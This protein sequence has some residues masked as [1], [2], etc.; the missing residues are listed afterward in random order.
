MPRLC[1]ILHKHREVFYHGYC[2]H[3]YYRADMASPGMTRRDSMRSLIVLIK[4]DATR[5]QGLAHEIC[6]AVCTLAG[7]RCR[8]RLHQSAQKPKTSYDLHLKSCSASSLR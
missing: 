2:Q 6:N 4:P 5:T 1:C 3:A 8:A 7:L